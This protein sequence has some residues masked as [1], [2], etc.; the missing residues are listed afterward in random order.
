MLFFCTLAPA[1]LVLWNGPAQRQRVVSAEISVSLAEDFVLKIAIRFTFGEGFVAE[2]WLLAA[3][4]VDPVRNP[5]G[6]LAAC[7][8]PAEADHL[9]Q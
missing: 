9:P 8:S 7:E 4:Y 1:L 2:N 6:D 5:S 3:W